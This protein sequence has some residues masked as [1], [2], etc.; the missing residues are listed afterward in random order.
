MTMIRSRTFCCCVPVRIGVVVRLFVV[1]R[2]HYIV[3]ITSANQLIALF[4][5]L[6]G[7]TLAIVGGLQAHTIGL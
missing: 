7:G 5:L 6:G 1:W 3:L 4:G 2:Q